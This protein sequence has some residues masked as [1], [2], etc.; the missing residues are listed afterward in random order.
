[1]DPPEEPIQ[2][3]STSKRIFDK[4]FTRD[5]IILGIV[6]VAMLLLRSIDYVLYIRMV[7]VLKEGEVEAVKTPAKSHF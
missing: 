2:D 6:L 3:G 7:R 5:N 1:M 4:Y